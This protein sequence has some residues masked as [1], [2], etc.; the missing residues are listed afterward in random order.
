MSWHMIMDIFAIICISVM[1]IEFLALTYTWIMNNDRKQK[2]K[3][4]IMLIMQIM[5]IY[6]GYRIISFFNG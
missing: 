4:V 3:A 1:M 5:I 6:G 2:L